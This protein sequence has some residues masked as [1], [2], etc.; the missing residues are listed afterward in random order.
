MLYDLSMTDMSN[1]AERPST[2]A[3]CQRRDGLQSLVRELSGYLDTAQSLAFSEICDP[4]AVIQRMKEYPSDRLEWAKYAHEDGNQCFTRNM[5]ERGLGKSNIVRWH[6]G[7]KTTDLIM[8]LQLI[9]VW[10]PGKESPVHDHAG[11]HC[12]MKVLQGSL[13]ETRYRWPDRKVTEECQHSPLQVQESTVL[14]QDDVTY[15]SDNVSSVKILP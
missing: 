11:S 6:L 14:S 2:S 3:E 12:V 4:N 1:N 15:I 8:V 13:K 5:V 7:R 10:T 9:L